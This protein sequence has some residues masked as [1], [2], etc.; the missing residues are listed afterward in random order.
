MQLATTAVTC[1]WCGTYYPVRPTMSNC[2]NCGGILPKGISNELGIKPPLAPRELP[3]KFKKQVLLWKNTKALVGFIFLCIGI[4]TIPLFGFGLIFTILG[5]FLYKNGK[6]EGIEKI[7][8]LENGLAT[9]GEIVEVTYVATESING[10]HPYLIKYTFE[11]ETG[12]TQLDS[13]KSWDDSNA[14]LQK[15]NKIWVVYLS[16]N[17]Q[18]SSPW[19]P[20]V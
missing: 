9:E 6:K 15:D 13:V 12:Q 10:K 18:I 20:M 17:P 5:Y 2:M 4:P 16:E 7:A 8:A 1:P 3:K 14:L 11:T 19:P